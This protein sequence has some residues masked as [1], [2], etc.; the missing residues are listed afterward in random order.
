MLWVKQN[1]MNIAILAFNSLPTCQQ[2]RH[3]LPLSIAARLCTM[4]NQVYQHALTIKISR[5]WRYRRDS[6]SHSAAESLQ[7]QRPSI[8]INILSTAK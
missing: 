4:T 5:V 6:F 8:C 7:L 1:N 2:L 3:T